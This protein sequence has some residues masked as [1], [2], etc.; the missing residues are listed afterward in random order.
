MAV[1]EKDEVIGTIAIMK[2]DAY[3]AELKSFYVN[4]EYRGN[5]ISKELFSIAMDFCK[6]IDL[7][8]VFLGTYDIMQTAIHFYKKRGFSEIEMK[9]IDKE[10]RFFEKYI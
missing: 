4:K 9:H 6:K 1:N 2:K 3:T 8:R 5:G 10:A 7:N